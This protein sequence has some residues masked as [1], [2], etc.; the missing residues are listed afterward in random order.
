MT[1]LVTGE[2][3]V[4]ELRLAKLASRLL[5]L[6]ID[7]VAQFALLIIG[8][9]IIGGLASSVD[10]AAA[11]AIVLVFYFSVIIGYPATFETLT[12]GRTLG[13]M[14]LGLRVV[15]DDGGSIR[16]RH[17]LVRDL[18]GSSRSGSPSAP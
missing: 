3:V 8:S 18:A 6:L 9:L 11:A 4:L 1:D 10:E 7:L 14:A 2:A 5:S 17:A 15:R 13:K 12:R 16:F